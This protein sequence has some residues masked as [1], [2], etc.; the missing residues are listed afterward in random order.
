MV[1]VEELRAAD[2][3][4]LMGLLVGGHPVDPRA[5][6]DSMYRG[7]SL[8]LPPWALRLTWTKFG[9][10]FLR[11]P[12]SGEL[13]GWNVRMRQD[14]LDAPWTPLRDSWGAR[15]TFGHYRV[16]DPAGFRVWPGTDSG[17]LIH[18]GQGGNRRRDPLRLAR[19]PLVALGEGSSDLLLGWTFLDPG[20]GP[21]VPTP[22]FFCLLRQGPLDHVA[23][24]PRPGTA[25]GH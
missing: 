19:D 6:D 8:G 21:L 17:L 4:A 14:G 12:S 10:T 3:H 24:P 22:A 20:R 23:S 25:R 16:V 13:R 7:I 2:R 9:K 11:D 1:T 18:Y 5:L 15:R